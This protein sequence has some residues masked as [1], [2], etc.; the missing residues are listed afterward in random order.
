MDSWLDGVRAVAEPAARGADGGGPGLGWCDHYRAW[1]AHCPADRGCTPRDRDV[2]D[3]VVIG[4]EVTA[5]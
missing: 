1:A 2:G 4:E 3:R 5:F